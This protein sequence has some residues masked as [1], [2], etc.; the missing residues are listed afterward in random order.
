MKSLTDCR[1]VNTT[2]FC[3][4]EQWQVRRSIAAVPYFHVALQALRQIGAERHD[5]TLAKLG[6]PDEEQ[7]TTEVGIGQRQPNHFAYS[8]S[9]AVQQ[10]EDR[11]VNQAS[12]PCPG[13]L[14]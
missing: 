7:I 6:F 13:S 14:R 10:S 5:T 11:L 9:Q 8:E 4:R 12:I 1:F 2:P 3:E